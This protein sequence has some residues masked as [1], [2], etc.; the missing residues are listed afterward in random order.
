MRVETLAATV[1]YVQNE[2]QEV[3]NAV[4]DLRTDTKA[5]F[6]SIR[7]DIADGKQ[8][9]HESNAE[10]VFQDAD[11]IANDPGSQQRHGGRS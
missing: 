5:E 7:G 10:F 9:N 11:R 8:H 2:V 6:T 1:E 3:Q 4:H